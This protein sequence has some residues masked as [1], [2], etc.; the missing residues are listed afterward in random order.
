M[1]NNRATKDLLIRELKLNI[2][3]F[4]KAEKTKTIEYDK[5]LGSLADYKLV[6]R[7]FKKSRYL[8]GN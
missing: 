7:K 6:I 8:V 1:K 3:S 4:E 5:L 2:M